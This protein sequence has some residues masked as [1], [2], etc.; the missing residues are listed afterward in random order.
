MIGAGFIAGAHSNAFRQVGRFFDVPY[1]CELQVVCGRTPVRAEAL[2]ARWGWKEVASDW[3][4]VVERRD[5]DLIDIAVPNGLHAPIALAAAAAGKIVLCEKP[6]AT[7]L[8]AAEAMA[9]A[10]RGVPNLVWFNYRRVPA[11]AFAKQMLEEGRA[12]RIFHYRGLYLNQSGNDPSKASGWR[13]RRAEAGSGAA[14][15]LLS[16][17]IDLALYL[18]GPLGELAALAHTFAPERDVDDATL[19]L[20]RFANGSIGTFEASRFGVGCRNRNSFEIHGS[21]GRLAFTLDAMNRLEFYDA[22]EAPALQGARELTVTGPDHPYWRNF[23]KPGHA[24]GYEHT[25]IATLGDFLGSL[26]R[27]E[28]FHPNF[29]DALAVQRVLQAA[30]Q[31]AAARGWVSVGWTDPADR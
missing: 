24:I 1:Q 4:A 14:G 16:H 28:S 22:T 7:S 25:F 31:S 17:S 10:A 23:W 20:A 3:R 5:L 27:G 29:D 2:A 19:L 13:Y 6:L 9:Q 11:V 12:G 18:N 15:D 21:K 8:S 30:E 26:A